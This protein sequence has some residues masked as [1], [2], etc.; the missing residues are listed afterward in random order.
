[1]IR[2][3]NPSRI[4]MAYIIAVAYIGHC[5][6]AY[7][8]ASNY[9]LKHNVCLAIVSDLCERQ[10][11]Y[12]FT[13][14]AALGYRRLGLRR[15]AECI[16]KVHGR[17]VSSAGLSPSVWKETRKVRISRWSSGCQLFPH[18]GTFTE[19]RQECVLT[20][21]ISNFPSELLYRYL[22]V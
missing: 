22:Y 3:S 19:R 16:I 21:D 2:N 9:V 13:Q 17:A 10:T 11:I 20:S 7:S 1:M 8:H 4:I 12:A 14:A 18:C 6:H 15:Q 5:Q